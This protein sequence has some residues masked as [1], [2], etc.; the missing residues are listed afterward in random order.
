MSGG[1]LMHLARQTVSSDFRTLVRDTYPALDQNPAYWSLMGH[2]L[3]GTLRDEQTGLSLVPR[4]LLAE[5]EGKEGQLATRNYVG[6]HLLDRFSRDVVPIR[7]SGWSYTNGEARMLEDVPITPQ[8]RAAREA[9]LAQSWHP[10]GRVYFGTGQSFSRKRQALVRKAD[11]YDALRRMDQAGCAEARDVISYMN[12]LPSNRFAKLIQ[13]MPAAYQAAQSIEREETRAW[14]LSILNAICD[15]PVPVYGP[16]ARTVRVFAFNNGLSWLK[17]DIRQIL[18]RGWNALDLRSAQLAICAKEWSVVEVQAF[19]AGN[20]PQTIWD[21]LFEYFGRVPDRTMKEVFK[22]ALYATT[23]GAGD[24]RIARTFTDA[25]YAED[26]ARRFRSHPLIHALFLARER[27]IQQIENDGGAWNCFGQWI[28]LWQI[29]DGR[30][31]RPIPNP[32]SVLAQLAQA[33]ELQLLYPAIMLARQTDQFQIMLWLHDGFY[34][35]FRHQAQQER[36]IA[37]MQR[38]VNQRAAELGIFTRLE[39]SD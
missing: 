17:R 39:V 13:A 34:V 20:P 32:R 4:W 3:L 38:V 16:S 25:G 36:W 26:D 5:I 30:G 8:V 1:A 33:R 15:Q 11:R 10:R 19:L 21:M 12:A 27:R 22:H 7:Y 31:G 35:A 29:R 9:E 14:Q 24:K 2:I 37:R 6:H 18:I 28:S 23:Y